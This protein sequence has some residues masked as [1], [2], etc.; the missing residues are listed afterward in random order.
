MTEGGRDRIFI[1]FGA[2]ELA[3]GTYD[4]DDDDETGLRSDTPTSLEWSIDDLMKPGL[5]DWVLET[6]VVY[7]FLGFERPSECYGFY[8]GQYQKC[9]VNFL[10]QCYLILSTPS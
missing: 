7:M 5:G 10:E 1:P 4:D 3:S 6:S 9:N 8:N 2:R